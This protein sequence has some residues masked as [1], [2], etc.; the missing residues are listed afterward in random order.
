M[1]SLISYKEFMT[2]FRVPVTGLAMFGK[3]SRSTALTIRECVVKGF[4][5]S[6]VGL[7]RGQI[8]VIY[9][10]LTSYRMKPPKGFGNAGEAILRSVWQIQIQDTQRRNRQRYVPLFAHP[11]SIHQS[12]LVPIFGQGRIL[13]SGQ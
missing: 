5:A 11:S 12:E 6:A 9:R 3:S 1:Y 8:R 13:V 2:P 10:G 4:L 7:C